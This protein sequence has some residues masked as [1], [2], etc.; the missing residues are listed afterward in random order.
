MKPV[1]ILFAGET[2]VVH[3][4]EYKGTDNFTSTRYAEAFGV[5]RKV[6][7][8]A[9]VEATHIPCHRVPFDFPNTA[10][11]LG[12]YDAVFFSDVGANTFLLHPDTTRLCRRTPNL[13]KLVRSYVENG[14]G[15]GMIG[16]YMTF[17]GMEAKAKYKDTPIE[18][19]LPVSL[20]CHD[21]RV[22]TPEGADLVAGAIGHPVLR[23]IPE[24][25]PFI[26][27]YNRTVAK[28]GAS[29]L[30]ANGGDP[31]IAAWEYGRGRS[32]AYCTDCAPHWAP[33]EMTEWEHYPALWRNIVHWL[34]GR[35]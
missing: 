34:A 15:F 22:E 18:E 12:R 3:A 30:V 14:G 5:M 9:G 35:I 33:P 4:V 20:L 16:G 28:P 21:D 7:E 2:C 19:I 13:L 17:Q 11:S 10:D 6:F 31:V 32:L 8:K 25:M 27:G 1:H 24:K 29:V 23:S 26:L